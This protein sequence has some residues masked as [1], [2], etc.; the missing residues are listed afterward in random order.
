MRGGRKWAKPACGRPLDGRVSPVQNEGTALPNDVRR[1]LHALWQDRLRQMRASVLL[2]RKPSRS[3]AK[4]ARAETAK[5]IC[6][7]T[8]ACT[9]T[10][11]EARDQLERK[12][13]RRLQPP[14]GPPQHGRPMQDL[15]RNCFDEA[16]RRQCTQCDW[17]LHSIARGG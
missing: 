11:A 8:C 7:A 12:L 17:Q 6:S 4:R 1:C 3:T 10:T 14:R 2:E 15:A 9:S 16:R 13:S 5:R